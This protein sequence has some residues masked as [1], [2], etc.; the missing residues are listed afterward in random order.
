LNVQKHFEYFNNALKSVELKEWLEWIYPYT[1]EPIALHDKFLH[2]MV[3]DSQGNICI[4][5]LLL[6]QSR[7]LK[8]QWIEKYA[9]LLDF[10]GGL[11][12]MHHETNILQFK[13]GWEMV[14][15]WSDT[16]QE[17]IQ[18]QEEMTNQIRLIESNELCSDSSHS[19]ILLRIIYERPLLGRYFR[20]VNSSNHASSL[21]IGNCSNATSQKYLDGMLQLYWDML[22]NCSELKD[23]GFNA[24][25]ITR[26]ASNLNQDIF[27]KVI[28]CMKQMMKLMESNDPTI[29]QTINC[30]KVFALELMASVNQ[31]IACQFQEMVHLKRNDR[32]ADARQIYRKYLDLAAQVDSV[33]ATWMS[34][35]ESLSQSNISLRSE[36]IEFHNFTINLCKMEVLLLYS[37]FACDA[38]EEVNTP[39]T[40]TKAGGKMF[41][42]D[43]TSKKL[44]AMEKK[45]TDDDPSEVNFD[46]MSL[47]EFRKFAEV[48]LEQLKGIREQLAKVLAEARQVKLEERQIRKYCQFA[49][50]TKNANPLL[51]RPSAKPSLPTVEGNSMIFFFIGS[52]LI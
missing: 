36:E 48:V 23:R 18:M 19:N 4:S 16:F 14:I 41:I 26:H 27:D 7:Y 20:L 43:T 34:S 1:W 37:S 44:P 30:D 15:K 42:F 45:H 10:I 28:E 40:K 35:L 12:E 29:N 9:A 47:S 3:K 5:H 25:H 13:W 52:T 31:K 22:P 46:P 8:T 21:G 51:N 32:E 2:A 38:S 39:S 17:A 11:Y 33:K 49:M 50:K 6:Y 24:I